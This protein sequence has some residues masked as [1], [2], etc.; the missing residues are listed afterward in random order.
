M[1]L[2]VIST[3]LLHF[4]VLIFHALRFYVLQIRVMQFHALQFHALL[5]G[6]SISCPANSCPAI[7]TVRH[8]HVRHFQSTPTFHRATRMHSADYAVAKCLSVRLSV[9]RRYSVNTTEHILRF[10]STFG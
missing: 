4:H 6:P 9:T 5:F 1:L 7:L 8:F 3:N 2:K 10:F